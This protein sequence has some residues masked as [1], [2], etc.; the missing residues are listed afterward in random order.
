MFFSS[1]MVGWEVD[2]WPHFACSVFPCWLTVIII[3]T[4]RLW[5]LSPA[6]TKSFKLP[7]L[8]EPKKSNSGCKNSL[9]QSLWD[10][11]ASRD[12]QRIMP[13]ELYGCWGLS[14]VVKDK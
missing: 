7:T 13:Y 12:F 8:T 14:N 3:P 6:L 11:R 10:L 2:M 5:Q 9:Y 4:W 1:Q